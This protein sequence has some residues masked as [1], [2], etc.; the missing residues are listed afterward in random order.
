MFSK[1]VTLL[2]CL[3][4]RAKEYNWNIS[5]ENQNMTCCV[6]PDFLFFCLEQ[7]N[8]IRQAKPTET[9]L[10]FHTEHVRIRWQWLFLGSPGNVG[11]PDV[12][13][14]DMIIFSYLDANSQPL[15]LTSSLFPC[16]SWYISFGETMFASAKSAGVF[17]SWTNKDPGLSCIY[18]KKI[19]AGLQCNW[20]WTSFY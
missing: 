14:L 6:F 9:R 10:C 11:L 13:L 2:V 5:T 17:T 19:A 12:D 1:S 20:N 15:Y 7:S 16:H 3:E 4:P 18:I 8:V